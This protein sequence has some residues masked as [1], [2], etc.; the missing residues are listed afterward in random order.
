MTLTFLG[1]FSAFKVINYLDIQWSIWLIN[2]L[3]VLMLL[4]IIPIE[5]PNKKLT[6]ASRR[7]NKSQA[8]IITF[9]C[10]AVSVILIV[11]GVEEGVIISIT[12]L[13]VAVLAVTGKIVNKK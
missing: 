3:S 7:K 12:M 10:F 2:V 4:P 8:M 1:V 5:N 11:L 6:E 9:L 13:S